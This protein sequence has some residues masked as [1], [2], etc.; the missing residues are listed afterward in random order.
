[1]DAEAQRL[2]GGEAIIASLLAHGID[3]VFGLPGVQLYGLFD[4]LYKSRTQIRTIS[5]RHEQGAG[6]MAFG[7]ARST[8]RPSVFAVVPGEGML[9]ASAALAT[10]QS[11]NA[12]VLCLTGQAPTP[13]LDRGRGQLHE[14]PDQLATM[15]TLAKWADRIS[16]TAKAPAVIACA[17]QEMRSGR[18]GTAAV[19][20]PWDVFTRVEEIQGIEPLPLIPEPEP[21]SG[22]VTRAAALLKASRA[23]MIFA[24]GGSVEAGEEILELAEMIEAPVVSFRGGRGVVSASHDLQMTAAAAYKLWSSTDLIVGIGTRLETMGWRWP[25]GPVGLKSIRI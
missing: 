2:T 12:P 18:P 9:N 1:M 22:V 5:T 8:G 3:T 16:T 4:A 19:E 25:Y 23:P 14:I 11:V 6:Y 17:F 10:A 7:Y 24:G 15:R 21:D 20:M 13:F